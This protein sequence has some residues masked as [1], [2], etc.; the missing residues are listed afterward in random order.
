MRKMLRAFLPV[1]FLSLPAVGRRVGF[2]RSVHHVRLDLGLT[3][4]KYTQVCAASPWSR[5]QGPP[6]TA[7]SAGAPRQLC[8]P[9]H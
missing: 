9:E 8:P 1:L 5:S 6:V 3:N 2:A 4:I 7:A